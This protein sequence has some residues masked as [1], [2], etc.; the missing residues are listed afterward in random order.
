MIDN[1]YLPMVDNT[2]LYFKVFAIPT[3]PKIPTKAA[4]ISIKLL[5]T[6][7]NSDM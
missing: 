1:E 4:P 2:I 6:K 7:P 5:I 3:T